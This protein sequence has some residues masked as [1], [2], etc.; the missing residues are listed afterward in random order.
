MQLSKCRS[1]LAIVASTG[2]FNPYMG[3]KPLH[4]RRRGSIVSSL[5]CYRMREYAESACGN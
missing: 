2:A 5:Q 4:G 3:G 1:T